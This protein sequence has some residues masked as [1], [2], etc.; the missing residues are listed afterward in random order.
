M[1]FPVKNCL[2]PCEATRKN[3]PD[4]SSD[5]DTTADLVDVRSEGRLI[6]NLDF[7]KRAIAKREKRL[8]RAKRNLNQMQRKVWRLEKVVSKGNSSAADDSSMFES[9]A[10]GPVEFS[11]PQP[12]SSGVQE[13]HTFPNLTLVLPSETSHPVLRNRRPVE[14][15]NTHLSQPYTYLSQR[16]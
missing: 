9:E 6:V 1:I 5:T 7:H 12:S 10:S 13:R 11:T 4:A 15:R 14:H 3:M 8:L 2:S 16:N